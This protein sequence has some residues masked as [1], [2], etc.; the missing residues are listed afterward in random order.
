MNK[1]QAVISLKTGLNNEITSLCVDCRLP[2]EIQLK[3]SCQ[4]DLFP[5]EVR[6]DIY[7]VALFILAGLVSQ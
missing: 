7:Y 4:G 3:P 1:R 5:T 2:P 6:R